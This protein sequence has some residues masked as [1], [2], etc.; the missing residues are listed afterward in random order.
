MNFVRFTG[1]LVIYYALIAF[2]G[3]V[4]TGFTLMLLRAIG[5]EAPWLARDWIVPCGA[6]GAI[7]ISAWLVEAKQSVIENM[8]PVLTR[9]FTPLFTILLLGFLA[10]MVATGSGLDVQRNL[11]ISFDLLLA[12]VVGLVLFAVSARDPHVPAGGFD[13]LQFVLILSALLVDLVALAA[14][15]SRISEFGF[16]ANKTAALGEN[17][18]LLVNLAWSGVLYWRFMRGRGTLAA[19][20]HWQTTYLPVYAAWAAVVVVGF[21]PVFGWV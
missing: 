17:L 6:L 21:P 1:E 7:I 14:I 8:A 9:I 2:G 15:A 20:E 13:R 11:L 19:L 10:T 18:V 3:V 16:S 12:I 4:F 5:V